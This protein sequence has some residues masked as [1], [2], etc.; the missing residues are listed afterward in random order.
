MSERSAH[1]DF[2]TQEVPQ[3]LAALTETTSKKFGLMTPQHMVEHL[4]LMTKVSVRQYGDI[5]D[6]R[7]EGQVKFKKFI[8][9]GAHFEYRPSNKTAADLPKLK[10]ASLE[11][12]IASYP[13]GIEGFYA[14]YSA[15]PDF[16]SYNQIQGA[17]GFKDLEF[18]HAR[19]FAYHLD[20][21]GL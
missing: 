16:L 4:V 20:Q 8:E 19:H 17:L 5:A 18:L 11:E 15:N 9:K 1:Q 3:R 12:A 6:P 21:F 2:L 14:H 10:Y 13:K 7:T